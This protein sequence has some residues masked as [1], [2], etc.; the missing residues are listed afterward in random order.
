MAEQQYSQ[1]G[2]VQPFALTQTVRDGGAQSKWQV[3]TTDIR[4]FLE[5]NLKGEKLVETSYT[6]YLIKQGEK[7]ISRFQS[8]TDD[9][10]KE[11]LI[12]YCDKYDLSIVETHIEKTS[13]TEYLQEW[14]RVK[15]PLLND[16]GTYHLISFIDPIFSQIGYL[17]KNKKDEIKDSMYN[18][19]KTLICSITQNHEEYGIN[20]GSRDEI[21]TLIEEMCLQVLNASEDGWT[22]AGM[23]ES[24]R[25]VISTKEEG[26]KKV[27]GVF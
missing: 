8:A 21:V 20:K 22:G 14:K 9:E 24:V 10:A 19:M 12:Q 16:V 6:I 15:S 17:S 26:R 13:Q 1:L 11:I 4:I 18:V 23:R 3:D 5:H 7:V 2:N 25:E 27:L